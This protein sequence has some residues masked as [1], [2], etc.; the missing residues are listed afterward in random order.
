MSARAFRFPL[1]LAASVHLGSGCMLEEPNFA[2]ERNRHRTS[3]D[4]YFLLLQSPIEIRISTFF[5]SD[6][7]D[8]DVSSVQGSCVD[9]VANRFTCS[10]LVIIEPIERPA[11]GY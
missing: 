10:D 4:D 9:A 7:N 5:A 11:A 1:L 6:S 3:P 8:L 2:G